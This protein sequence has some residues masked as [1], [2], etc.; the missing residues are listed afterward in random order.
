MLITLGTYEGGIVGYDFRDNNFEQL[1]GYL[2]HV[3]AVKSIACGPRQLATGGSDEVVRLFDLTKL[4]E[5]GG[6]SSHNAS[7]T[8]LDMRG[9]LLVSAAQDGT[10]AV[11]DLRANSYITRLNINAHKDSVLSVAIH[12]S[13]KLAISISADFSLK[14]WDL[15][16][17]TC[18]CVQPLVSVSSLLRILPS[19]VRLSPSG[20]VFALLYPT[21]VVFTSLA[22]G[23]T[24]EHL[25]GFS[26]FAFLDDHRVLLGSLKGELTLITLNGLQGVKDQQSLVGSTHAGSRIKG[27][28]ICE[29]FV[30]SA[31]A[32][33]VISIWDA[34][35]LEL[36]DS[37]K[38]KAG[39]VTCLAV[40]SI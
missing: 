8:A 23:E 39:R 20:D 29:N 32:N 26:E 13:G 4:K 24:L 5:N 35:T 36:V 33:G 2:A 6:I 1:Y 27:I 21:K 22:D 7:I 3:G 34:K 15:V 12:P 18:A 30:I 40:S 10:L 16:R 38:T 14:L 17:G 37:C 19:V 9:D 25:G 31:C 11:H 28:Q